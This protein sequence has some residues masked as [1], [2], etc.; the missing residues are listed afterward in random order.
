VDE[1]RR[2]RAALT[3]CGEEVHPGFSDALFVEDGDLEVTVF[4]HLPGDF[5]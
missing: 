4:R 1:S 2:I 3:D 5:G